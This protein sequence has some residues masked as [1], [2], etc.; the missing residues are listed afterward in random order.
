MASELYQIVVG[1]E[2]HVQLL[3]RTKLF[4]GCSTKFGLPPNSATCPVCLGLPGSLPVMN[5]Q[6]FELALRGALAL[7]CQIAR[8]TKWD[9]KNYYYPDLPKNYQISQYD[10]PMSYD[11]WLEINIASNPKKDF[12]SKRIGII[13][14]HLEEDAGKSLHDESGAG[15]VTRI[16]LNRTGTPLLEIVSRPEINSPEEAVAYLHEMRLLMRELHV[17]DCEMQEGSLRCDANVNIHMPGDNGQ[18][19]ATPLVEVKN[20]NSIRAVERAIK[21]EADRQFAAYHDANDRDYYH[22]KFGEVSKATAGWIDEK[23]IT[24]MQRRKEEASD[25]R[26][27]PEPDLAPVEVDNAWLER[28]KAGMGELPSQQRQRL[29]SQYGLSIYDANVLASQGRATVDYFEDVA[30]RC[31]DPK[32]A[33]N[34]LTNQVLATL[35]ER[36]QSIQ[37][38]PLKAPSLAELI[39]QIKVKGLNNQRARD[40]YAKMLETGSSA[41]QAI[42][43]LGIKEISEAELREILQKAISANAK[44]WNDFKNGNE[45]AADRI[46]GTVMKETKGMAQMELVQKLMAELKNN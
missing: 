2:V 23:G 17:S 9:R 31:S 40:V 22:K 39:G 4:C 14:A 35:N 18:Q 26:Y 8:F 1:L 25:Y 36:K 11:G 41:E 29:H 45:K 5:R 24:R 21:Y 37:D 20:L 13:R 3:T 30:K 7:N 10:L 12:I 32:A 44:A 27:F 16:D 33:S 38:F 19:V 43:A 28:V 42:A 6:A 46:K 15:G 34:W